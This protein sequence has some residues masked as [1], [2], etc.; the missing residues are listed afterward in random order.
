MIGT[1]ISRTDIADGR[2]RPSGVPQNPYC[3]M[4]SEDK[5]YLRE[6]SENLAILLFTR[7][8]DVA[9]ARPAFSDQGL[10]FVLSLSR[11]ARRSHRRAGVVV[12]GFDGSPQGPISPDKHQ[13]AFLSEVDTPV[14]LLA[15]DMRDEKF[16]FAWL[17][18]PLPDGHL[19]RAVEPVNVV[20]IRAAE[21]AKQLDLARRYYAALDALAPVGRNGNMP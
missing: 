13:R 6:R 19:E 7:L 4:M 16:Y 15:V 5:W 14:F 11:A 2:H 17:N 21:L 12:M 3:A 18:R 9:V 8:K 1:A 10:D 20:R